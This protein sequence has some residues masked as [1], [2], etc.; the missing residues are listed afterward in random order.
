M[1]KFFQVPF[2]SFIIY[3]LV[4]LC[5]LRQQVEGFSLTTT[6]TISSISQ[7]EIFDFIATPT[8]WPSIVASSHSVK[9]PLSQNN[10]ID[11]P[12]EVGDEVEEVFGLPPILP[13]SVKW[14]CVV[15]D[16][17]SGEIKF[18]SKEGVP[19]FAKN[20]FMNF[21]FSSAGPEKTTVQLVMEYETLN[22][23]VTAATPF[24]NADNNLALKVLLPLALKKR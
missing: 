22:P 23:L 6:T 14:K 8:N 10:E 2:A 18:Y 24:L 19:N 1:A 9:K 12:L 20:C 13:L 21:S 7:N 5:F 3:S 17:T 16:K 15:K 4:H 11:Q